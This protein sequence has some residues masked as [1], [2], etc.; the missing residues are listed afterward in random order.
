MDGLRDDHTKSD[1]ER[2]TSYDSTYMWKLKNNTNEHF[3]KTEKDPQTLKTNSWLPK[4]TGWGEGLIGGLGMVYA[5][6]CLWN[7]WSTGSCCIA[8][9]N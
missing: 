7:E 3:Y 5:H 8:Q 2:Q 4:G 9:G 6:Y 1:R